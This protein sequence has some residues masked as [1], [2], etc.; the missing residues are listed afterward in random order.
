MID[1]KEKMSELKKEN[2]QLRK[3]QAEHKDIVNYCFTKDAIVQDVNFCKHLKETEDP[4][5]AK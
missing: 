5:F 4:E 1:Y 3:F 2:T